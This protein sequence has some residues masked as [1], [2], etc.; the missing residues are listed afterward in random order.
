MII[1]VFYV[2][3]KDWAVMGYTF[4]CGG[5]KVVYLW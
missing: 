3:C 2:L 4:W 1:L 5:G